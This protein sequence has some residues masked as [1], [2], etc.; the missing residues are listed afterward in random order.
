MSEQDDNETYLVWAFHRGNWSQVADTPIPEIVYSSE[1]AYAHQGWEQA[2]W[3]PVA[4]LDNHD[5]NLIYQ[6]LDGRYR[7]VVFFESAFDHILITDLPSLLMLLPTIKQLADLLKA[8]DKNHDEFC[9]ELDKRRRKGLA[10]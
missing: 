4:F 5:S 2:G 7:Y 9:K 8:S 6:R 3:L 10:T 1:W